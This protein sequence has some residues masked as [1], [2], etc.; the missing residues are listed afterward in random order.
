MMLM[1]PDAMALAGSILKII[2]DPEA[3]NQYLQEIA[4]GNAE[5]RELLAKNTKAVADLKDAEKALAPAR[6]EIAR[7]EAQISETERVQQSAAADLN[8]NADALNRRRAE[9]NEANA[10]AAKVRDAELREVREGKAYIAEWTEKLQAREA[11][12]AE[13]QSAVDAREAKLREALG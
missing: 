11:A 8:E 1:T 12:L 5:Q 6:E 7:R 10:E 13:R 3:A 4:A 2:A 9:F